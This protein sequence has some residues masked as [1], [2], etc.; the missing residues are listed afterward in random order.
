VAVVVR[1]LP[2]AIRS[3]NSN[4]FDF[5]IPVPLSKVMLYDDNDIPELSFQWTWN[6]EQNRQYLWN[7]INH[8]CNIDRIRQNH[9]WKIWSTAFTTASVDTYRALISSCLL[10]VITTKYLLQFIRYV[11]LR[12]V[13]PN[14]TKVMTTYILPQLYTQCYYIM[15]QIIL[16][17]SQLTNEQ[18]LYEL[19]FIM[20]S[21]VFYRI[22]LPYLIRLRPIV[23]DAYHS[24]SRSIRTVRKY[25]GDMTFLIIVV[26]HMS[27]KYLS[28]PV[29]TYLSVRYVF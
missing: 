11:L 26:G 18:L 25:I 2:D 19:L 10:I 21:I 17:H 13:F 29:L 23:Q 8:F 12:I 5:T 27:V 15:T 9:D 16:F 24:S 4:G 20:S 3:S 22:C 28:H 7:Q 1:L 6:P 14:G